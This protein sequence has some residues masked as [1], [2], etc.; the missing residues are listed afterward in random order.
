MSDEITSELGKEIFE[1]L[2]DRVD[3]FYLDRG[4]ELP[5]DWYRKVLSAGAGG[6]ELLREMID[7]LFSPDWQW[8][9]A[10]HVVMET[11]SS[12]G[13][14]LSSPTQSIDGEELWELQQA[15]IDRDTSDPWN[16]TMTLASQDEVTV[17]IAVDE[18]VSDP[19]L[20]E[21]AGAFGVDPGE[22][23]LEAV[24]AN[25]PHGQP[26]VL[27]S[28]RG[29]DLFG[30]VREVY[31]ADGAKDVLVDITAH[32]AGAIDRIY[33]SGWF[34]EVGDHPFGIRITMPYEEFA[35]RVWVDSDPELRNTWSDI[36]G[37]RHQSPGGDLSI[38]P[39]R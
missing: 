9:S 8:E 24:R 10:Y 15:V 31:L 11:A 36:I 26:A 13:Y 1:A 34:E 35:S 23:W 18:W 5:S 37:R 32:Q 29:D 27:V 16:L 25:E 17:G 19:T 4:D 12:L 7:D 28:M 30:F 22:A 20:E 2:P 6:Q 3:L 33:G 14:R 21:L 38:R 39:V